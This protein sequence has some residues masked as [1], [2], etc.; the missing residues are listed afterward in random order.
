MADISTEI[1]AI[2]SA[3]RGEEVRD[4]IIDALTIINESI[5]IDLPEP[6]ASDEG[7][8]LLVDSNGDWTL[9]EVETDTGLPTPTASD[10]GKYLRVDSN[11]DWVLVT[12]PNAEGVSF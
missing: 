5:D 8:A 2:E 10:S 6:T 1:A 11:G 7:K 4:S 12:V 9:G 3:S